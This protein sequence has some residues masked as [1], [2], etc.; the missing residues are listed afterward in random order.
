MTKRMTQ[1][2]KTVNAVFLA[3]FMCLF[4]ASISIGAEEKAVAPDTVINKPAS[5]FLIS[6]VEAIKMQKDGSHVYFVDVRNAEEFGTYSIPGSMNM[7][8][9]AIESKSYL[10]TAPI[11]IVSKGFEKQIYTSA[12]EK[13]SSKGFNSKVMDG[14]LKAW[15]QFGGELCGNYSDLDAL[16]MVDSGALFN[17]LSAPDQSIIYLSDKEKAPSDYKKLLP[18]ASFVN[19]SKNTESSISSIIKKNRTGNIHRV[20]L[21]ADQPKD[22]L[23]IRNKM[24]GMRDVLFFELDGGMNSVRSYAENRAK[25]QNPDSVKTVT[26]KDCA[27]CEAKRRKMEEEAA[28]KQAGAEVKK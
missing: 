8:L 20:V 6:A 11:I 21:I 28:R 14:G 12:C 10:K 26:T 27:P 3:I 19:S 4:V 22:S 16:S 18:G 7:P 1:S 2:F 5:S 9:H 24:S 25:I 15:K 23:R 17:E 13:L